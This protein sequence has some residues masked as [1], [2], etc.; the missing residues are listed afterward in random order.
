MSHKYKINSM[1][2]TEVKV[3]LWFSVAIAKYAK[4]HKISTMFCGKDLAFDGMNF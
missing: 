2:V 4:S 1:S 3:G